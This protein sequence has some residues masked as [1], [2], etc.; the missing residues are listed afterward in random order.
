MLPHQSNIPII[1]NVLTRNLED[2]ILS[3]NFFEQG[4]H[5]QYSYLSLT[6]GVEIP[7]KT[8]WVADPKIPS[9]EFLKT[10]H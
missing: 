3:S 1:Q 9:D 5:R 2:W 8:L 10:K 7:K 4:F 6:E